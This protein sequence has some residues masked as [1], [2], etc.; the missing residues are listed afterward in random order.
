[1]LDLDEESVSRMDLDVEPE[2]IR[3]SMNLPSQTRE[4]PDLPS[5]SP[6]FSRLFVPQPITSM[7]RVSKNL[8]TISEDNSDASGDLSKSV[9]NLGERGSRNF[10]HPLPATRNFRFSS[11]L[12]RDQMRRVGTSSFRTKRGSSLNTTTLADMF[13][14]G[15]TRG[16]S[17]SDRPG[18]LPRLPARPRLKKEPMN[19]VKRKEK[20]GSGKIGLIT[21]AD[22]SRGAIGPKEKSTNK[23]PG[24]PRS[25]LLNAPVGEETTKSMGLLQDNMLFES[26]GSFG[27][28]KMLSDRKGGPVRPRALTIAQSSV[29]VSSTRNHQGLSQFYARLASPSFS[30][31]EAEISKPEVVGDSTRKTRTESR[32]SMFYNQPVTRNFRLGTGRSVHVSK[33]FDPPRERRSTNLTMSYVPAP[34][35][36]PKIAKQPS[37]KRMEGERNDSRDAGNM[38]SEAQQ[39]DVK[40]MKRIP[41]EMSQNSK[42]GKMGG[43]ELI[44]P[45]I[46]S[47]DDS[48]RP[49]P[50][51]R[52][53][54]FAL[55]PAVMDSSHR[56][57]D[58]RD[59]RASYVNSLRK[60]ILLP[61]DQ[62]ARES[63]SG[64]AQGLTL[65]A[66][67]LVSDIRR[68]Q[69]DH[70]AVISK[71]HRTRKFRR[72][73]RQLR[74][75]MSQNLRLSARVSLIP[76]VAQK[77][78]E[79]GEIDPVVAEKEMLPMVK[80][81]HEVR[82]Q[83]LT[84][85]G[86]C[87][88][89]SVYC[90]QG[91]I[92]CLDTI[93]LIPFDIKI[94]LIILVLSGS[95]AW[96]TFE[97]LDAYAGNDNLGLS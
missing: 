68:R 24:T 36:P 80:G 29:Q 38:R 34:E 4:I 46:V 69:I 2:V 89:M 10:P 62:N 19:S 40:Q 45:T 94:V 63:Y 55:S 90:D 96:A 48:R 43:H 52:M 9:G 37:V 84:A 30:G 72:E 85:E 6:S 79:A 75:R 54:Y 35:P 27:A 50:S 15:N 51:F 3:R 60:T 73:E 57:I 92:T 41:S 64:A 65:A 11:N 13:G 93:D 95:A 14:F 7:Q 33:D 81:R 67:N 17:F 78:A 47:T 16:G 59:V 70:D 77:L 23:L 18:Y 26:T 58:I 25:T 28:G 1:M 8:T 53:S 12:R 5:A 44:E 86:A 39:S 31:N 91:C 61:S 88:Q 22:A 20:W 71:L 83:A 97:L 74:A 21:F 49:L 32:M 76:L 66:D 56:S 87:I 82:K 42:T